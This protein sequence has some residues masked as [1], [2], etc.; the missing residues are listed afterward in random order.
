[1]KFGIFFLGGGGGGGGGVKVHVKCPPSLHK[2]DVLWY[3]FFFFFEG[4]GGGNSSCEMTPLACI[5]MCAYHHHAI[6]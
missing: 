6:Y 3:N 5:N 4:G 1:M 2:Y